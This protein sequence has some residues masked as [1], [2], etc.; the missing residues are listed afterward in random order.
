MSSKL[1]MILMLIIAIAI[2][3][4]LYSSASA[5]QKTAALLEEKI[6]NDTQNL[7]TISTKNRY[8]EEE[9]TQISRDI[10]A[11]KEKLLSSKQ[12]IEMPEMVNSNIIV[13][14]IIDYGN[15]AGVFVI[16]LATEDWDSVSID[17]RDYHVFK[18][19]IEVNGSQ[20][21]VIDFTRQVQDKID[22]YLVIE[23][24]IISKYADE[25]DPELP[26][27]YDTRI[28]LDIALYAR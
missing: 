16:P 3:A 8:I 17:K 6:S 21:N 27:G 15:K 14:T 24:L 11:A 19:S 2:G 25:E 22:Q 9:I 12:E 26:A 28:N 1:I 13:K 5:Q 10:T 4:S 7:K 20:Q 18:M 23:R